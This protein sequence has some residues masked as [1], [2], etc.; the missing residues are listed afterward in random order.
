MMDI[1]QLRW[2]DIDER[3]IRFIRE[4]TKRTKKGDPLTITAAR[5]SHINTIL[6]KWG[7]KDAD[8]DAYVFNIIGTSVSP[9]SARS[10]IQQFTKLVNKW[11][12]RIGEDLRFNL[13]LTTYVARHSFATILLRS[14][15]PIT[16][17]SQ[18]LGHSNV[19]T[20][21]KYFA[22]FDLEAQTEYSKALVNF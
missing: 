11:M 20:T 13:T 7:K 21:Q 17:A 15:A 19:I 14:G 2:E 16:F 12:K 22:G 10:K 9:K 4:K 8:P 18:S 6:A 3:A 1:A 5:N